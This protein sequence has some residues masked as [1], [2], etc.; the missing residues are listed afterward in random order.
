M[1]TLM[2]SFTVPSEYKFVKKD[3]VAKQSQQETL[4]LPKPALVL[5]LQHHNRK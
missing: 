5:R 2:K 4:L 1:A 3:E